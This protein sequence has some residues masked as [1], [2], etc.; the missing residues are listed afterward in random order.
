MSKPTTTLPLRDRIAAWIDKHGAATA[1]Q[2]TNGIGLQGLPSKVIAELNALRTEGALQCGHL[3][4]SKDLAY[5]PASSAEAPPPAMSPE[6]R[7]ATTLG[8][9]AEM[10]KGRTKAESITVGAIADRMGITRQ[11]VAQRAKMLED[12]GRAV[13]YY[14]DG[15]YR[16]AHLYDPMAEAERAAKANAQQTDAA[17]LMKIIGEI[18]HAIG[19][20][21]GRLMLYDLADTVRERIERLESERRQASQEAGKARRDANALHERINQ[22]AAQLSAKEDS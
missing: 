10:V 8:R 7:A 4:A 21:I 18:R 16:A 12:E 19:D 1:A 20:D 14:P 9:M 5:W 2:I 3:G 17:Y 22:L 11:A 6:L 15:K 13:R